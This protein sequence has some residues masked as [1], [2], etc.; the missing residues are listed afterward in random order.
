M[1]FTNA[2]VSLG[3]G[4]DIYHAL[5]SQRIKRKNLK[6][7]L[8]IGDGDWNIGDPPQQ[9]AMKLGAESTSV[10]TDGRQRTGS[11]GSRARIRES[12]KVRFVG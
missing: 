6:A 2:E 9:A 8:M 10:Y 1:S 7:V 12:A 3:D 4:T 5:E 11:K